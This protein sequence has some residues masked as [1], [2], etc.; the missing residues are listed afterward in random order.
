LASYNIDATA[1]K[2]PKKGEKKAEEKKSAEKE[3]KKDE[4]GSMLKS[5][6]EGLNALLGG[7]A[8]GDS[9]PPQSS[10][11]AQ[12]TDSYKAVN[13]VKGETVLL[14]F[15]PPYK[16]VVTADAFEDGEKHEVLSLRLTLIGST[17]E[18]CD[19]MTV[20]GGRPSKPKFTITD[21]KGKV[22]EE[23]RFEYG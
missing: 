3:E 4:K 5:L 8:E 7:S 22:V 23:G 2:E 15:G 19:D 20:K 14:P 1:V 10:V 12:A 16:P 11:S 9:A 21:A 18:I 6:A 13:V 17:G